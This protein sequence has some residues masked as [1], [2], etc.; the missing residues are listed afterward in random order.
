MSVYSA[1]TGGKSRSVLSQFNK[2]GVSVE[3]LVV[4][5]GGG[6]PGGNNRAG[7]GGGAGGYR[8][9]V[10]G[11]TSGGGAP[12]EAAMFATVGSVYTLTCGAGGTG[13]SAT[14]PNSNPGTNGSQSVFSTIVSLGG[15]LGQGTTG[16]A[17][18]GGSGGGGNAVG[19][20]GI[21]TNG[22]LGT[23]NQGTN[24]RQGWSSTTSGNDQS[25]GGGGGA[26]GQG[27]LPTIT[28]A[29]SGGAGVASSITGTSVTRGGGGGGTRRYGSGGAGGAG[30][31][32]AGA[33]DATPGSGVANT[34]SGG[35]A[36]SSE[37]TNRTGGSGGS[38]VIIL[39]YPA[40][41]TALFS[42]G[43]SATTTTVGGFK[44]S[45]VTA[46]STTSEFVTFSQSTTYTPLWSYN[47]VSQSTTGWTTELYN[48]CGSVSSL[49]DNATSWF[50]NS[51][52]GGPRSCYSTAKVK[53]TQAITSSGPVVVYVDAQVISAPTNKQARIVAANVAREQIP[54][55][56]RRAIYLGNSGSAISLSE[57]VVETISLWGDAAARIT[58]GS[59]NLYGVYIA[60]A[61]DQLLMEQYLRDRGLAIYS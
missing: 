60:L 12:A 10:T 15:G 31:G 46:T 1:A 6:G 17:G 13:G 35:G 38:G 50:L 32:G 21:G 42:A 61:S 19:F 23:T 24:G 29:G 52:D 36:T 45:S 37:A 9:S 25:S 43:V 8:C 44:V 5:G 33:V 39:K 26:G 16:S 49:T 3:Y 59:M 55:M 53:K 22:G 54:A 47:F 27:S 41:Y 4:A 20:D 2:L 28:T 7:G 56:S 57:V 34:G 58:Q 11:E 18:T 48:T 51:G 30:G 40:V 14:F